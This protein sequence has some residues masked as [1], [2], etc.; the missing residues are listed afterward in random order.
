MRVLL[1]PGLLGARLRHRVTGELT[2]GTLKSVYRRPTWGLRGDDFHL[3]DG[4]ENPNEPA[5]LIERLR[6][7][8]GLWGVDIYG[9]LRRALER[10]GHDVVP[11]VYDWRRSNA[12]AAA[13]VPDADVAVAHSTGGFVLDMALRRGAQIPRAVWVG[14]PMLGTYETFKDLTR[15]F[16]FAPGGTKFH[17]AVA[18]S[19]P[20]AYEAL[21]RWDVVEGM[22]AWD[23]QTWARE[24]WGPFGEMQLVERLY[25]F[26]A[27]GLTRFMAAR[28]DAA[29][30]V[31]DGIEGWP[32]GRHVVVMNDAIPTPRTVRVKAPGDGNTVAESV[33]RGGGVET[34]RVAAR[35]RYLLSARQGIDAV[36][37][38]IGRAR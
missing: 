2:W 35:H 21:P 30:R 24:G 13:R 18:A 22:D 11:L 20:A 29:R 17:P 6:V 19:F 7:V 15:P 38:W 27:A 3:R 8:P 12:E 33:L 26:D 9:R 34:I 36:L 31:L 16:N 5:D 10:G 4:E 25:G 32:P 28:F 37:E 1:I 14:C 23:A